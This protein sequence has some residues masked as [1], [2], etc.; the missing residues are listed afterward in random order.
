MRLC[1]GLCG[2]PT[3]RQP[4][5]QCYCDSL[6][7]IAYARRA[8]HTSTST[9]HAPLPAGV[10]LAADQRVL[11]AAAAGR[12]EGR[13]LLSVHVAVEGCPSARCSRQ[14]GKDARIAWSFRCSSQGAKAMAHCHRSKAR[15]AGQHAFPPR[16][17]CLPKPRRCSLFKHWRA[18]R[19]HGGTSRARPIVATAH[20]AARQGKQSHHVAHARLAGT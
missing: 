12:R 9:H 11:Q 10:R 15:S 19:H 14:G 2:S 4:A 16:P 20:Q 8:E 5:V 3:P 1:H 13:K 18:K 17:L 6:A 7:C